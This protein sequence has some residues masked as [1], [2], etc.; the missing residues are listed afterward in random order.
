MCRAGRAR[1]RSIWSGI[2]AP[3]RG[4]QATAA[5][6]FQDNSA[7]LH[8]LIDWYHEQGQPEEEI[9][10]LKQMREDQR[11]VLSSPPKAEPKIYFEELQE[12]DQSDVPSETEGLVWYLMEDG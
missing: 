8:D 9:T 11:L 3:R 1:W 5:P 2:N 4:R 7:F 12:I 10:A 6:L